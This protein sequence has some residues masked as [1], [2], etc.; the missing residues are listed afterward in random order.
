MGELKFNAQHTELHSRC[1]KGRRQ[2]NEH[3]NEEKGIRG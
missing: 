1:K 3:Y 2:R